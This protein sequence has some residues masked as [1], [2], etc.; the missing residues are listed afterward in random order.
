MVRSK[1]SKGKDGYGKMVTQEREAMMQK[2]GYDPGE[3]K[4][5]MHN[6]FGS[7]FS[8]KIDGY[9]M[10]TRAENTAE[11][12]KHRAGERLKQKIKGK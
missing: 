12:N 4:V 6:T 2:L 11:S 1:I 3:D 7:H 8:K 9:H 5:A 10:G